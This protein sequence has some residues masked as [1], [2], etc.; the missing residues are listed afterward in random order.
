[1]SEQK[2]FVDRLKDAG[3]MLGLVV[4]VLTILKLILPKFGVQFFTTHDDLVEHKNWAADK[5]RTDSIVD[6]TVH[7]TLLI[8]IK[9]LSGQVERMSARQLKQLRGECLENNRAMLAEQ[10]ML[11]DCIDLG[12]VERRP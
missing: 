10:L 9:R 12:L 8:T 1:M 2:T 5:H 6:E 3:V 7:D 4:T 11:E